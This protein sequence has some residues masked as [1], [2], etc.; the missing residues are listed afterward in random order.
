MNLLL[1]YAEPLVYGVQIA[2]GLYGVYLVIVC[3]RAT[4]TKRFASNKA[5]DEFLDQV[6]EKLQQRDFDGIAE[7]CDS[8]QYWNKTTAQL[9]LVALANR[10]RGPVKLRQLLAEKF[11]RDVLAELRHRHSWIATVTRAAPLLGLLGT[12]TSMVLAFASLGASS[13]E[14][15]DPAKLAGDLSL[16]LR[17]TMLGLW[18]AVP[19]TLL[20]SAI[21]VRIGKLTDSVQEQMGEFLYDLEV[22]M[23]DPRAADRKSA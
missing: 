5:A 21:L 3:L 15:M 18:I 1:E 22:A 12:V 13:R 2:S 11:E 4:R 20:G 16:A 10:E 9:I 7:L 23:R 19:M 6:R 8:P 14:G 17:A